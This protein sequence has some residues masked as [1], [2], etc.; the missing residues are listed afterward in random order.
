[1]HSHNVTS[2]VS[3]PSSN[4]R[5]LSFITSFYDIYL[6]KLS[7]TGRESYLS[8]L[9]DILAILKHSNFPSHDY[10]QLNVSCD[11]DLKN[12]KQDLSTDSC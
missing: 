8:L 10:E 9:R 3:F 6:F 7:I 5:S 1:M 11:A 12:W 2:S 4:N